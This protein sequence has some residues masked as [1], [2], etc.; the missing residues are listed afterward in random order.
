ML[1][2]GRIDASRS[3]VLGQS[4]G[5]RGNSMIVSPGSRATNVAS[6]LRRAAVAPWY[7]YVR[8]L[9]TGKLGIRDERLL[10]D[11]LRSVVDAGT[12]PPTSWLFSVLGLP[13]SWGPAPYSE[14]ELVWSG[15][16]PR[17]ASY[18]WDVGIPSVPGRAPCW[19][20]SPVASLFWHPSVVDWRPDEKGRM[21]SHPREAWFFINGIL[22][23]DAVARMNGD[24]LAYL[25]HRPIT[26]LQNSTD[27]ALVD[28]LECGFERL[29]A[30][31]D[32]V[33]AAF[34]PVM[35]ALKDPEKE[36]VVVI[37]H[38]QGT[39][40]AAVVLKLLKHVYDRTTASGGNLTAVDVADIHSHAR[41]EG[42]QFDRRHIKSLSADEV[43]KLELYCFANCASDMQYIGTMNDREFPWIESFGNQHDIVARLGVVAPHPVRDRINI[44]G[45]CYEH[46]GAWGHLLNVHYLRDVE[47][48]MLD[49]GAEA[50]EPY[51]LVGKSGER[52]RPR[53]YGYLAGDKPQPDVPK[54]T[55]GAAG[56]HE[57]G[58]KPRTRTADPT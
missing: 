42:M 51:T 37:A 44:D 29:G 35:T 8:P 15:D 39:L 56:N 24:Y 3:N 46:R 11:Q 20:L 6:V 40:I 14:Y 21:C 23:D 25:F 26:L 16:V 53:L 30:T 13:C 58:G 4:A 34:P 55:R 57:N 52:T 2:T 48:A 27:G 10:L 47:R 7:E 50:G 19:V 28:L 9:W 22:T 54:R 18:L 5:K 31:A 32:D 41:A 49:G 1:Y 17:L 45:P 33:D 43:A 36:R 12:M 38:S